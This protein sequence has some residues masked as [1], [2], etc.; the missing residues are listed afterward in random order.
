MSWEESTWLQVFYPHARVI[1]RISQ[2]SPAFSFIKCGWLLLVL[3]QVLFCIV[4]LNFN[5]FCAP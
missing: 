1:A 4:K 2:L 5:A 3:V